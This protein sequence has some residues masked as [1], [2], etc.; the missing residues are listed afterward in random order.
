MD[1]GK[2]PEVKVNED[3]D[4]ARSLDQN[5]KLHAMISRISKSV[6]WAGEY[7]DIDDWKRLLTAAWMRANNQQAL[8]VPA[9][10]GKGFDVLYKRTSKLSVGE[11]SELIE[12]I[13]AWAID[14]GVIL[15]D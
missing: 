13:T 10:D 7:L 1:A 12:Y 11:C 2:T 6:M 5:A 9:L 15:D 3:Y 14:K 4:P 8:I